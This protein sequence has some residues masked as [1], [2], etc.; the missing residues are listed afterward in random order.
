MTPI[1]SMPPS[2]AAS[3]SLPD[4]FDSIL[5][6]QNMLQT[7]VLHHHLELSLLNVYNCN[8]RPIMYDSSAEF[9]DFL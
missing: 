5:T 1:T 3:T 8:R 2:M 9:I 4:A 7:R 6:I